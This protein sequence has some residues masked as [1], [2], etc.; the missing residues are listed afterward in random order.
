MAKNKV[1]GL[2]TAF[3]LTLTL[4]AGIASAYPYYGDYSQPAN[5]YYKDNAYLSH[6]YPTA[7][8]TRYGQD[9]QYSKTQG[10]YSAGRVGYYGSLS[11][12]SQNNGYSYPSSRVSYYGSS[13]SGYNYRSSY[14]YNYNYVQRSYPYGSYGYYTRYY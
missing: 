13:T 9:S 8:S 6:Q 11:Q 2:L 10:Y 1:L 12:Y 7:Y 14:G 5:T 4:F 3:L